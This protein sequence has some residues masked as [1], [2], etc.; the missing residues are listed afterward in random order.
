M[1]KVFTSL[2][3]GKVSGVGGFD[4]VVDIIGIYLSIRG[5]TSAIRENDTKGIIMNTIGLIGS[6]VGES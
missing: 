4:P 3:P 5:L 1:G 2:K 6:F